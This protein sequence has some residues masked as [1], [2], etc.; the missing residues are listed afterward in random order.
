MGSYARITTYL[1]P[2]CFH[3]SQHLDD[4]CDP[5]IVAEACNRSDCPKWEEAMR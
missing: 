2:F 5:T 3:A 4:D 1:I